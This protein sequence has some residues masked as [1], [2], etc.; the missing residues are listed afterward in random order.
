MEKIIWNLEKTGS[1][2]EI[3]PRGLLIWSIIEMVN[4]LFKW[5]LV[6]LWIKIKTTWKSLLK[7]WKNTWK[8]TEKPGKVMEFCQSGKVGTLLFQC[9]CACSSSVRC[10][11]TPFSLSP[12]PYIVILRD[13]FTR[14]LRDLI[15]CVKFMGSWP[16]KVR[17]ANCHGWGA[18]CI[19]QKHTV[20]SGSLILIVSSV[21]LSTSQ[22]QTETLGVKAGVSQTLL[23]R[24][25]G[26]LFIGSRTRCL[27]PVWR[28]SIAS[29]CQCDVQTSVKENG[30]LTGSQVYSD[31][32]LMSTIA[33]SFALCQ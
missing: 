2:L 8:F 14:N 22:S 9:W 16:Y 19:W 20:S 17:G 1:T 24:P 10:R 12:L 30:L 29:S 33:S 23:P 5:K 13:F 31:L 15:F 11:N 32:A 3:R 6:S 21:E 26:L 25:V 18:T 4:F 28:N 27:E 7:K